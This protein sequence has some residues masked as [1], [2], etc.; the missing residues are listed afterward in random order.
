M[1]CNETLVCMLVLRCPVVRQ[2]HL[3]RKNPIET[4]Y[5][6][7]CSIVMNNVEAVMGSN[8][9]VM[10]FVVFNSSLCQ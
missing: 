1:G 3:A 10:Y 5:V 4:S 2:T 9:V 8:G 6:D 7:E